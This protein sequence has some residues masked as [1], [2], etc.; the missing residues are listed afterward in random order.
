MRS[1]N[2]LE[3]I[4]HTPMVEIARM[5]PK[6]SVHIFAK[7][8]GHNPTGSVKDRIV[9]YML[10][11]AED[12]G[13]LTKDR[14]LLE[15]TSGNTGIALAMIGRRKGYRVKVVLPENVSP[16]RMS[17]LRLY[18]AEVVTSPAANST[19]GAIEIAQQLARD[20]SYFMP[21]QYGN[22]A[23]P[24]AHYETTGVEILEDLPEVDVFVA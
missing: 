5:S 17:L 8:E 3:A 23:N 7:L 20:E 9:K 21:F 16:E 11:Q 12:S 13:Q 10:E 15:A 18:G 14:I 1:K 6:P 4:G 24:L 19:D 22:P 2:I